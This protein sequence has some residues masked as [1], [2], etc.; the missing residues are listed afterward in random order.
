METV[1]GQS[2]A[3]CRLAKLR[4]E[5]M[6]DEARASA[7]LELKLRTVEAEF[8]T[9]AAENADA[10]AQFAEQQATAEQQVSFVL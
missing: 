1:V 8:A 4:Y 5:R 7:R 6:R 10:R 3:R 2:N 9:L